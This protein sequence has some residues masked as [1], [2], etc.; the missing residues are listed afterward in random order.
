MRAAAIAG[1]TG[2]TG[3]HLLNRLLDD[4]SFDP[5]LSVLRKPMH[6]SHPRLQ[7]RVV[8]FQSLSASKPLPIDIA[9]CCLGTT[10]R[11]AGSQE[12]FR[13]ID[14]GYVLAFANWAKQNG[15]RHF[16][17]VS[18]VS[19]HLHSSNFYLRVKAETERDL[20]TLGFDWLDIF[21][22]SFLL[23]QRAESRPAERFGQIVIESIHIL[24]AGPLERYRGIAAAHVAAAM[25]AR[26]N[27][28]GAPGVR[29]HEWRSITSIA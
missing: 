25:L 9:F 23:G 8:D 14:H 29:R 19:A 20:E 3:Q 13:A 21:Q 24:L 2:L 11:K 28:P 12:A 15:A 17:F 26:A 7:E 1:A 18:S 16:L 27:N 10:I 6:R 22:P 4:H 5:V